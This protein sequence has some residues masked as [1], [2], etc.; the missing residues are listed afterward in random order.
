MQLSSAFH[1]PITVTEQH[2]MSSSVEGYLLILDQCQY[3]RNKRVPSWS[4]RYIFLWQI[5]AKHF[6]KCKVQEE[7]VH[8]WLCCNF[9]VLKNIFSLDPVCQLQAALINLLADGH[10]V[11]V[12]EELIRQ[13]FNSPPKISLNFMYTC[14]QDAVV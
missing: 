6:I 10:N 2:V 8:P 5:C 9:F 13:L 7:R 3:L 4:A 11:H 12:N 14:C 1:K